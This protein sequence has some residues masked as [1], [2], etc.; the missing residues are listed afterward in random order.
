MQFQNFVGNA[1]LKSALS[2][3]FSRRR[4]PHAILLQ[5][6]SGLGKRT[7][8]RI[9]AN[10]A[11]CRSENREFSPCGVCPS[12]IRAAAGSHP[13]IRIVTGSGK[14][15]TVS[16][17]AVDSVIEDAYR[18]PEEADVSVY[19]FF[20]ENG[21][22]DAAQNKLLKLIEEPPPGV[23]FIFTVPSADI[24]LP[25]IRSRVQIF[26]VRP[27]EEEEAAAYVERKTGISAEEAQK[28]AALHRGNIGR[29]LS[30]GENGRAAKA[31]RF[32]EEIVLAL[33]E[34][35]EHELLAAA[36][37]LIKEKGLFPE[38]AERMQLIFRDAC[39]MK[40]GAKGVASGTQDTAQRLSRRLPL[41]SL[42]TL[43]EAAARYAGYVQR[44]ANMALMVTAFCA[45][46]RDIAGR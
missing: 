12:C 7:L 17:A 4:L 37:P 33:A 10:A 1:A 39:M 41:K 43:C 28:L 3:A 19:L 2:G 22:Q 13:D 45:E 15:D 30:D 38:T 31:A 23:I 9:L 21:I 40:S 46:M 18:R 34:G 16:A 5:G 11:V 14:S 36:A 20:I 27:P 26:T 35:T 6:E 24:L 8:A 44:N 29:M 42:M 32:A 25:T